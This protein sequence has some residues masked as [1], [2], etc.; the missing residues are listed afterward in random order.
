MTK[1]LPLP[2]EDIQKNKEEKQPKNIY[3]ILTILFAVLLIISFIKPFSGG[4]SEGEAKTKAITHINSLLMGRAVADVKSIKEQGDLYKLEIDISGEQIE[5]YMTKDG[6]LLFPS[7]IDMAAAP[8]N[9]ITGTTTQE[10]PKAKTPEVKLFVMALCPFGTIAENIIQPVLDLLG[11]K[12]SFQLFFIANE[13]PDGSFQSLHG[14][15]EVDEN[16]RQLCAVKYYPETY[17]NYILC[18]NKDYQNLPWESCINENNMPKIKDCFQGNEGKELLSEN[19]KEAPKYQVSG[20]PTLIINEVMFQGERT[21]EAYKQ[22]VCNAF[23][24]PPEECEEVLSTA[25][26]TDGSC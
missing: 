8:L 26:A 24:E 19:I 13:N 22:A 6:S 4:I 10:I 5:S 25:Q 20:S 11:D 3:K 14:Q 2:Q 15:L 17:M 18:F 9:A 1:E 7:A 21:A 12:I 16:I 23:Q